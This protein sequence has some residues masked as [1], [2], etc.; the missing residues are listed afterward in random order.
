VAFLGHV[1]SREGI[2]VDPSKVQ[3]VKDWPTLKSAMEIRSFLGLPG[4]YQRFVQDFSRI[5]GPLTKLTQKGEK[6]VWTAKCASAF[7]DLKKR[8]MMAPILKMPDWNGGM[9]IYSD[10]SRRG[11]GCVLMQHGHVIAYASR[12]LKPHEKNYPTHDLE[13]AAVI[14]NIKI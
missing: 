2:S 14:F 12:Q 13:L 10:A 1:V 9:V 8:L 3:T 6:Y 4:Y 7:K 5:A 11:L